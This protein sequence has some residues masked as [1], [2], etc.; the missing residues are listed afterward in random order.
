MKIDARLVKEMQKPYWCILRFDGTNRCAM[1]E[2][3]EI[4]ASSR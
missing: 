2:L 1:V 3:V 4:Q